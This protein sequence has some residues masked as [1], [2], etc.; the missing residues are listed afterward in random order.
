[1]YDTTDRVFRWHG[2]VDKSGVWSTRLTVD[3]S[4]RTYAVGMEVR[5]GGFI[6]SRPREQSHAIAGSTF[7]FIRQHREHEPRSQVATPLTRLFL[8]PSSFA[9]ER[10][11]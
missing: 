5:Q 11:N 6:F 7:A 9:I 1:M 10:D 8:T 2:S 4:V 3:N